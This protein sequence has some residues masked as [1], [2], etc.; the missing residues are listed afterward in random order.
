MIGTKITKITKIQKIIIIITQVL[1]YFPPSEGRQEE[2]V[3]TK[4]AKIQQNNNNNN[5]NNTKITKK[6][7]ITKNNKK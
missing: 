1:I 2:G 5:N 7:K 4:M 3:G 6:Y